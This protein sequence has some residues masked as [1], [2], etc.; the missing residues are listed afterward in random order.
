[1]NDIQKKTQ[2]RTEKL[3]QEYSD[4]TFWI[5]LALAILFEF[6]GGF[7]VRNHPNGGILNLVGLFLLYL[8]FLFFII[9]VRPF[10]ITVLI[11]ATIKLFINISTGLASL[12]K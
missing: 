12:I 5:S 3:K 1:M 9:F 2:V 4:I 6:L 11:P 10:F 7:L 8:A